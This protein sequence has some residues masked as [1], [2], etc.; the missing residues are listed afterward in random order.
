MHLKHQNF[1]F[2]RIL[3]FASQPFLPF[4][5]HVI[6]GFFRPSTVKKVCCSEWTDSLAE[7]LQQNAKL[8][9]ELAA[10]GS[11]SQS[12]DVAPGS[13]CFA[14]EQLTNQRISSRDHF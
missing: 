2:Y 9:L 6:I 12:V 13:L 8:R 5:L 1:V 7:L 4:C 3:F 14:G 11:D 10:D